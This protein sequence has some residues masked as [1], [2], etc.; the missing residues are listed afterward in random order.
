MQKFNRVLLIADEANLVLAKKV[1]SYLSTREIPGG[2]EPFD[3]NSIYINMFKNK[4]LQVK[5][6]RN[7]RGRHVFVIKSFNSI[8]KKWKE[9]ELKEYDNTPTQSYFELFIINDALKRASAREITNVL[10]FMP[11]L[12]QDKKCTPRE[13]VTAKV[14]SNLL[15]CSGTDRVITWDAHFKQIE[16]FFEINFDNLPTT[17]FFAEILDKMFPNKDDIV[18][19]S[20]DFG[21]ANRAKHL[22]KEIGVTF[23]AISYKNRAKDLLKSGTV[24]EMM[25]LKNADL[26][27]K[28][29]IIYDDMV[30]SGGSIIKC[31]E[32]LRKEGVKDIIVC[33]SHPILSSN[34]TDKLLQAN[35]KLI[36]T[37]DI[38]IKN[39]ERYPNIKVY[40]LA[41]VIA[42]AIYCIVAGQ[43][44]SEQ[45]YSYDKFK[46][47]NLENF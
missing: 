16:G 30:D 13:P 18:V 44:M 35:I 38:K 7:V 32:I 33:C 41:K 36:T 42:D 9:G 8:T 21:A 39:L 1:H 3:E 31:S 27:G 14:V 29:A 11:Y 12:R 17:P 34:A 46:S 19:V 2:L 15:E 25:L 20:P 45:V 26:Y 22:A 5:I 23:G 43:S 4:E 40:S 28:I 6:N 24:E 47:S 10:P 37:D